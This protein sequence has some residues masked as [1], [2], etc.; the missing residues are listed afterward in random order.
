MHRTQADVFARNWCRIE[1][2]LRN[3]YGG[4]N[5][6]NQ[7]EGKG[8]KEIGADKACLSVWDMSY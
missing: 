4:S 1:T 6:A 7:L 2:D 8:T 3:Y 5:A